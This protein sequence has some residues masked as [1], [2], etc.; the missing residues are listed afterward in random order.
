MASSSSSSSSSVVSDDVV[1]TP[2]LPT[3]PIR[4]I[5]IIAGTGDESRAFIVN[6]AVM[7]KYSKVCED[8]LSLDDERYEF[9]TTFSLGTGAAGATSGGAGSSCGTAGTGGAMPELEFRTVAPKAMK[10][11]LEFF[12]WKFRYSNVAIELIPEFPLPPKTERLINMHVLISSN[13]LR[14]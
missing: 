10:I 13:E 5:K 12:L 4:Y 9:N 14:C 11:T 2:L 3:E 1:K 6:R 7:V 8:L